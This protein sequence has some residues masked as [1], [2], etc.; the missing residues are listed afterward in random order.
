VINFREAGADFR[1]ID[2]KVFDIV[3]PGSAKEAVAAVIANPWYDDDFASPSG[4]LPDPSRGVHGPYSLHH[5]TPGSFERVSA[6]TMKDIVTTWAGLL[7][8]LPDDFARRCQDVVTR[9]LADAATIYRLLDLGD[10]ARHQWDA[11]IG[12]YGFHEFV[13][14]ST[15]AKTVTV[16]V[17]SDD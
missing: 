4:K 10:A 12:Q 8:P 1:W 5:I 7:G 13:T 3:A 17:A 14:V 16:L 11:H 2:I 15:K 6:R 9:S